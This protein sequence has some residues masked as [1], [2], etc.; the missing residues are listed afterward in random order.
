MNVHPKFADWY[1]TPKT[2]LFEG[3]PEKRTQGISSLWSAI[4]GEEILNVIRI[5]FDRLPENAS[6]KK[7]FHKHFNEA[8]STFM[9]SDNNYEWRVLAGITIGVNL[10][11]DNELERM[12]ALAVKCMSFQGENSDVPVPNILKVVDSYVDKQAVAL[13][14]RQEI[15]KITIPRIDVKNELEELETI[16]VNTAAPQLALIAKSLVEKTSQFMDRFKVALQVNHNTLLA[17]DEELNIMWWV[18][19]GFS[20][21]DNSLLVEKS[22]SELCLRA[23]GELFELTK[24]PIAPIGS[25]AY[26]DKMLRSVDNDYIGKTLSIESVVNDAE[27]SWKNY[28]FENFLEASGANIE[29][30]K[31]FIPI[32]FALKRSHESSENWVTGYYDSIKVDPKRDISILKLSC[33]FYTELLFLKIL[34]SILQNND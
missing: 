5:F 15:P 14:S 26:L 12:A 9:S 6:F 34:N 33:Q 25:I 18:V 10:L 2:E 22:L 13:R 4:T 16:A 20:K 27:V 1:R 29:L 3:L 30:A 32:F 17:Q 19:G 23:P 24:L 8:D 31:D 28:I 21:Y 7:I 11:H